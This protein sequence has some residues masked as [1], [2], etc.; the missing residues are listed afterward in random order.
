MAQRAVAETRLY[1]NCVFRVSRLST[2][3]S[4]SDS[5]RLA[6]LTRPRA[7]PGGAP[8]KK[9]TFLVS[10]VLACVAF[11]SADS[12]TITHGNGKLTGAGLDSAQYTFQFSG[13]GGSIVVPGV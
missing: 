7:C 13:P 10:M 9:I 8:L 2:G 5:G 12:V 4:G 6:R 3:C 11:S 1:P